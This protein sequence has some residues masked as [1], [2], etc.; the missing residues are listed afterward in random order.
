MVGNPYEQYK[1]T[2]FE[3]A[4]Q[5]RLILMLYDGVLKNLRIAQTSIV[6]K[7]PMAANTSLK[8]AQDIILELNLT[9]NMDAGEIAQH[10][11][12]L[13]SYIHQ[14][15]I[16]ANMKKDAAIV[17]EAIDLLSELKE[18]WETIILKARTTTTAP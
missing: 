14:R 7:K 16:E 1:R 10:L 12:G 2:Q 4:S 9:L 17:Q 5:G 6:N 8:K 11:R 13:Y 18:A 3:T 15:L